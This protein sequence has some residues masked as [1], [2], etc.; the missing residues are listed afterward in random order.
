MPTAIDADLHFN[1]KHALE[2]AEIK[3]RLNSTQKKYSISIDPFNDNNHVIASFKYVD[4]AVNVKE[5]LIRKHGFIDN[6]FTETYKK[7]QN[8]NRDIPLHYLRLD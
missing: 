2:N 3:M 4:N 1:R 5:E 7:M 6:G 8:E